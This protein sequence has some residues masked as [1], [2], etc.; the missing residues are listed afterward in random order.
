MV[1]ERPASFAA[2]RWPVLVVIATSA[3]LLT[4]LGIRYAGESRPRWLDQW[5]L[6]LVREWLPHRSGVAR[7]FIDLA[8]PLP[9][10]LIIAVLAGACLLVG[11]RRLAVLAVLG[12][13]VTGIATTVLKELI[14]RTKAGDLAF[15]SGHMGAATAVTLV[16]ALLLATVIR[17]RLLAA[18]A[19]VVGVT[20]LVGVG[21]AL[22]MTMANYHYLTDAV[23]GFCV[24]VCV[25]LGLALIIERLPTPR[26]HQRA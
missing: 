9:L 26:R 10:I 6:T 7:S 3:L 8:D 12:P 13:G 5:A 22:A 18:V 2:T 25:V 19:V 24:A 15:P 16:F 17:V 1:A 14:G 23:G 4:V 20:G 21:M 11:A